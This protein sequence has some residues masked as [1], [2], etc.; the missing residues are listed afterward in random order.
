[1]TRTWRGRAL[2]IVAVVGLLSLAITVW[3]GHWGWH[4]SP[5]RSSLSSMDIRW[6]SQG[7]SAIAVLGAGRRASPRATEP[8]P[9]ASVAK[10]MTA[11]VVVSRFPLTHGESGF[12]LT[13]NDS[14]AEQTAFDASQGE[15]YVRVAAGEALTERQA[16]EALLLPSANNI[17]L[18]LADRV[19]GDEAAFVA[20]MNGQAARLGMRHTTYTDPSGLAVTTTST[21]LD[22]LRLARVALRVP[23]L[24]AI[25]GMTEATIPI[26]GTITNTDSLL[27]QDGI[28]AGKT[29]SD[30]AAG[31]CFMFKAVHQVG[32]H[33]VTVIGIVLGQRNGPLIQAGLNAADNLLEEVTA[34]L[35]G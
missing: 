6:P 10:V 29:G 8:V 14:D 31:G 26:A 7:S 9:I 3:P 5:R 34:R 17:A 30:D 15:S 21:A 27:R 22:Q 1:M 35:A 32:E 12:T 19:A 24:S 18:A 4:R 20:L 23:V 11:Y 25:M 33:R 28:V 2:K 13:L 16:L